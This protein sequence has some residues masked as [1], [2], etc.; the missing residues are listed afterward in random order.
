MTK[1]YYRLDVQLEY[2]KYRCELFDKLSEDIDGHLAHLDEDRQLV[3]AA[4]EQLAGVLPDLRSRADELR[5]ELEREKARQGELDQVD[6]E[7]LASLREGMVEQECVNA[8]R[9]L[10]DGAGRRSRTTAGSR[11]MPTLSSR[12]CRRACKSSRR[13][14]PRPRRPSLARSAT[15]TRCARIR[16][17]RSN[18]F[19]VR[20]LALFTADGAAAF[21][22]LV[23]MSDWQLVEFNASEVR[24]RYRRE[25]EV[26]L[27]IVPGPR[28]VRCEM[29]LLPR[30]AVVDDA[31]SCV[32]AVRKFLFERLKASI[33]G[34]CG[35]VDVSVRHSL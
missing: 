3:A 32:P 5:V 14:A 23:D 28:V 9:E 26:T 34:G 13:S 33:E 7:H 22:L 2:Y 30:P 21:E 31:A 27:A 11:P 35:G 8:C 20:A 16:G 18:V 19:E 10:I 17:S 1:A 15:A 4:N 25:L 12:G 24:L 6:P 29:V